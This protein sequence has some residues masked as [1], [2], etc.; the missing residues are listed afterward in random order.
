[1]EMGGG[2][3]EMPDDVDIFFRSS[4]YQKDDRI[5]NA[6]DILGFHLGIGGSCKLQKLADQGRDSVHLSGYN[7]EE[8]VSELL[9]VGPSGRSWVKVLM[10]TRGFRSFMRQGSRGSQGGAVRPLDMIR[11]YQVFHQPSIFKGN[12]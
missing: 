10:A 1:M 11:F 6:V 3:G 8:I 4:R 5:Q 9:V 12:G 7:L 2:G